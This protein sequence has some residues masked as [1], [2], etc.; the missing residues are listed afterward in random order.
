M[1]LAASTPV[2]ADVQEPSMKDKTALC[3]GCTRGIGEAAARQL[4][5]RGANVVVTG[6]SVDAGTKIA[7]DIG[8]MFVRCDMADRQQLEEAFDVT[9]SRYGGI[10]AVFSNGGTEGKFEPIDEISPE[11]I[12]S[13]GL[14]NG[15]A[16]LNVYDL[17][18]RAFMKNGGGS[19]VF[20]SSIAAFLNGALT[21]TFPSSGVA[22]YA[23][24]KAIAPAMTRA[25]AM[26]PFTHNIRIYAI[27]PAVYDTKMVHDVVFNSTFAR[28]IDVKSLNDWAGLNPLLPGCASNPHDAAAAA[29]EMLAN[30]TSWPPSSVIVTDGPFTF[31]S[32]ILSDNLG[33][34]K[35]WGNIDA[36]LLRNSAGAPANVTNEDIKEMV[37]A[38]TESC[39]RSEI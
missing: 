3:L 31:E 18:V 2:A 36:S 26:L 33:R 37:A 11:A 29:V 35:T 1:L 10:D 6:R 7:D 21:S 8:G 9:I 20:T 28:M 5:S 12:E 27:A 25:S 15:L 14:V 30:S 22:Y 19:L 13:I 24:T 32:N 38:C 16:T 17:A 4:A 39:K 23:G 34:D